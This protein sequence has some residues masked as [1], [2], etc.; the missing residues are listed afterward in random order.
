[1]NVSKPPDVMV[2]TLFVMDENTGVKPELALAIIVGVV[3]KFCEPGFAKV[4]VCDAFGVTAADAVDAEPEPAAFR[5]VTV[6]V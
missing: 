2:Q 4:M 1:M 5:A 3:P 6:N